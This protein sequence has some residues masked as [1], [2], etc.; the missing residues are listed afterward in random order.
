MKVTFYGGPHDG[1][2]RDVSPNLRACSLP[3]QWPPDP[4]QGV[5]LVHYVRAHTLSPDGIFRTVMIE[6][7]LLQRIIEGA[8]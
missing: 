3:S 4:Q 6:S 1:T 8:P 2:E 5:S 7:E